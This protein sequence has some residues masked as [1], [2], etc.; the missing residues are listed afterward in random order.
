VAPRAARTA[1]SASRLVHWAIIRIDTL[2]HAMSSVNA[3]AAP[4]TNG[5]TTDMSS[6]I[7]VPFTDD[8]MRDGEHLRAWMTGRFR[9]ELA[10]TGVAWIELTGPYRQRLTTAIRAC[11]A[12]L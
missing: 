4:R 8:G 3:T 9:A 12:A 11:D 10:A 1:V 7:G 2:A 6:P 5:R